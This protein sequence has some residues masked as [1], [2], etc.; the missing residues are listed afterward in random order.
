[1]AL[2]VSLP[3]TWCYVVVAAHCHGVAWRYV[4]IGMGPLHV[5]AGRGGGMGPDFRRRP[6]G[7]LFRPSHTQLPTFKKNSQVR[8]LK[9]DIQNKIFA[10]NAGRFHVEHWLFRR[11][12]FVFFEVDV[13]VV[14]GVEVA[15]FGDVVEFVEAWWFYWLDSSDDVA[16]FPADQVDESWGG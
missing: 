2:M 7:L 15:G 12:Y 14:H 3:A 1:M 16:P 4:A 11:S 10:G 13:Q 6:V 9:I 5:I 8:L